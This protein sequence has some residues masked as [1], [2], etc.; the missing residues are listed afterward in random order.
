MS[1]VVN[2][3]VS[4]KIIGQQVDQLEKKKT[5]KQKHLTFILSTVK[6]ELLIIVHVFFIKLQTLPKQQKEKEKKSQ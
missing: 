6:E 3:F 4:Y 5:V 2:V 1:K